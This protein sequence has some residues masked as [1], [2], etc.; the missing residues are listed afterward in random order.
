[1]D[2]RRLASITPYLFHLSAL[3]LELRPPFIPALCRATC[4]GSCPAAISWHSGQQ[5]THLAPKGFWLPLLP[6][7][8][9]S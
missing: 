1:M 2:P 7:A 8:W 3:D 5:A 4:R 6:Q 9:V